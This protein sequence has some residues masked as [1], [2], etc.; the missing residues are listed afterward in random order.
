MSQGNAT[1]LSDH[2]LPISIAGCEL[3]GGPEETYEIHSRSPLG[4]RHE[5]HF[6]VRG[7]EAAILRI[8]KRGWIGEWRPALP[9]ERHIQV[10]RELGL[11]TFLLPDGE[12]YEI[13]TW[14][15]AR[16]VR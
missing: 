7:K 12:R 1:P 9:I 3:L 8:T 13:R 6:F 14:P 15:G 10:L 11:E 16:R 5:T 4:G 2:E